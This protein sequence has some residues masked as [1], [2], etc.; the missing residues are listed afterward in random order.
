MKDFMEIKVNLIRCPEK[1][2]QISFLEITIR[3]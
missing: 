2:S 1:I 3:T